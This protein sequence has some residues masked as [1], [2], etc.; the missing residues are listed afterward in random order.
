VPLDTPRTV[1]ETVERSFHVSV[2]RHLSQMG[3]QDT[4]SSAFG[5]RAR[6]YAGET[7]YS[8][9]SKYTQSRGGVLLVARLAQLVDA[10]PG[11]IACKLV[12][13]CVPLCSRRASAAPGGGGREGGIRIIARERASRSEF[14]PLRAPRAWNNVDEE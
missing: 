9:P 14:W 12:C 6:A 1:V 13:K 4:L 10:P 2:A 8:M 11:V 7:L 5:A 3:L